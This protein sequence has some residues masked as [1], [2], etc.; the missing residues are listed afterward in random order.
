MNPKTQSA[1]KWGLLGGLASAVLGL[2]FFV[3]NVESSSWLNYLS[4]AVMIAVV[5]AGSYEYRDKIAGGFASF[6]QLLGFGISVALVYGLISS[7]WAVF[8]MEVINP[9]LVKEILLDTEI[10]MEEQGLSNEQIEQTLAVTKKMMKPYIFFFTSLLSITFMGLLVSLLTSLVMRKEKSA[11]AI[12]EE[13][14][15]D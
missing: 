9:E 11:E 6:K 14:L 12:I 8:F 10:R 15:A 13:K 2:L 5:I 1:V 7:L 3:L 4:F